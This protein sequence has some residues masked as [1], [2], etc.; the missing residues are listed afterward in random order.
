MAVPNIAGTL[1]GVS[2]IPSG[3][4]QIVEKHEG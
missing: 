4:T 3:G 2:A 1:H